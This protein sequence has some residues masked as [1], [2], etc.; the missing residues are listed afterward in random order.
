MRTQI[1]V[2]DLTPLQWEYLRKNL[3]VGYDMTPNMVRVC[4]EFTGGPEPVHVEM[5]IRLFMTMLTRLQRI[6][7]DWEHGDTLLAKTERLLPHTIDRS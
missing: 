6:Q 1:N 4:V 5:P 2:Q 7:A 3:P